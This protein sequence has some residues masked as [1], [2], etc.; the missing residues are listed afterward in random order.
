TAEAPPSEAVAGR[1]LVLPRERPV[2][3]D[4]IVNA[5]N[6]ALSHRL[7][8]VFLDRD[9]IAAGLHLNLDRS[10]LLQRSTVH[11]HLRA[12]GF[13]LDLDARLALRRSATAEHLAHAAAIDQLDVVGASSHHQAGGV[14]HGLA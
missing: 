8:T 5:D 10:G 14:V 4:A 12:L 11:Y 9:V 1:I 7:I 3:L 6:R 13:R 2:N